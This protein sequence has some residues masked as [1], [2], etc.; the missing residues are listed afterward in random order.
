VRSTLAKAADKPVP[1]VDLGIPQTMLWAYRFPE[2]AYSHVFRHLDKDTTYPR[3]SIDRL[4]VFDDQGRLA[5]VG[6]P[7]TRSMQPGVG[8]GYPLEGETTSIPLD[9][10]VIGGGWWLR[11]SYASPEPVDLHLE[12]GD[13]EYDLS[14]PDG[15]HNLFVQASGTF[16]EVTLSKYPADSEF[17]VTGLTLGLPVPTPTPDS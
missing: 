14:L 1:L 2:N 13:E 7:A 9:G 12:A 5:P 17:C 8:C 10:P 6:I 3:S 11:V 16:D 15:L 4:F